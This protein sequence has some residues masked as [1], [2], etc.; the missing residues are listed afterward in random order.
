[1]C[2][3]SPADVAPHQIIQETARFSALRNGF[4]S[5]RRDCPVSSAAPAPDTQI[6]SDR[7]IPALGSLKRASGQDK[8][9][10]PTR[11]ESISV[12][13]LTFVNRHRL[14]SSLCTMG[15]VRPQPDR[16]K[17]PD[18]RNTTRNGRRWYDPLMSPRQCPSCGASEIETFDATLDL[19]QMYRCRIC[20][21]RW[22]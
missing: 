1:L 12:M 8:R 20:E 15:D 18:R 14:C 5:C 13:I 6:A 2:G 4:S 3:I 7:C 21:H 10:P 19:L 9:L 16:R 22:S 17:H 11:R